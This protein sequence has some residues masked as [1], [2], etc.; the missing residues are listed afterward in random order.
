MDTSQTLWFQP[1]VLRLQIHSWCRI[2]CLEQSPNETRKVF[3]TFFCEHERKKTKFNPFTFSPFPQFP[4]IISSS[5]FFCFSKIL[6]LQTQHKMFQP[7]IPLLFA[8]IQFNIV[9]HISTLS[10]S[11]AASF[12]SLLLLFVCSKPKTQKRLFSD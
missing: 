10:K 3:A 9:L 4:L 2:N 11:I 6:S 7:L 5:F 8:D 12:S 1:I